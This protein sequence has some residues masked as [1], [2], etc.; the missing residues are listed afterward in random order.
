[1]FEL[2]VAHLVNTTLLASSSPDSWDFLMTRGTT[3][4]QEGDVYRAAH[5][6]R[7]RTMITSEIDDAMG[8]KAKRV[9]GARWRIGNRASTGQGKRPAQQHAKLSPA[10]TVESATERWRIL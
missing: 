10:T 5:A 1:M 8:I 3:T 7:Q 6:T 9:E 4:T 2:F